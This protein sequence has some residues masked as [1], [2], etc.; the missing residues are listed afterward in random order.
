M[1]DK[2][3]LGYDKAKKPKYSS[4]TNQGGNKRSYADVQKSPMK[5]EESKKSG[6]SYEKNIT[7]EVSKRLM[8]NRYQHIFLGHCYACN[9]FGHKVL[10]CRTLRKFWEYKKNSPSDK[11]KGRNH[12]RFT[13][14]QRYDLYY[15]KCKNYEL[16]AIHFK[17]MTPT[18]KIVASKFQDKNQKKDWKKRKKTRNP[19]FPYAQQRNK[20]YGI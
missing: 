2:S 3:G 11:P 7:N 1:S 4:F 6:P 13:H 9:N 19:W 5:K 17:R 16:M 10:N 15:Y 14:L 18:K 12:N 8:T 20:I